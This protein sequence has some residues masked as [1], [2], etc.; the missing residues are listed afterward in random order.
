MISQDGKELM[1]RVQR[2]E[3]PFEIGSRKVTVTYQREPG[4][5]NEA[6]DAA[7]AA[8]QWSATSK[9]DVTGDG[10][11]GAAA[12]DKADPTSSE[13]C[14]LLYTTNRTEVFVTVSMDTG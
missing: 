6:A 9:S 13:Y 11:S 4:E 5:K 2:L 12:A 7:I 10:T 1:S 8:A 3:P 14:S